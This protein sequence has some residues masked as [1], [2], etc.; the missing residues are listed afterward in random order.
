MTSLP[1][2][3]RF[4]AVTAFLALA[5]V[6][7][8]P[9]ACA[10][11]PLRLF[12]AH[13]HYNQEAMS[14]YPLDK[15]LE[16]FRRNGVAGIL[17]TSRP[18]LGTNQLVEAKPPGLWV[19]P[20]LRPYRVRSDVQTW[21][22]DPA[23]FELIQTEY[24]RGYYRGIGEFHI[25]GQGAAAELVRKTV[26]FAGARDLFLHAHCDEQA[27]IILFSHN[28]RAR[29]IWAHTGF[30]TPV[31]RV[32]ELLDQHPGLIAEMSYRSGITDGAGQLTAEWRELFARYSDRVVIGS[33][34]WINERWFGYDTLMKDYR[35]W[36]AQLPADQAQ[37]IAWG[38]AERLFGP[39]GE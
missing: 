26:E 12:D 33:D 30:T 10:Q 1:R 4:A 11:A 38:N 34:T 6:V 31:P 21:S 19:V 15:A 24:Q 2:I 37:R 22:T 36:L 28:P 29:I 27:L 14:L 3:G 18:N 39:R 25:Y 13:L 35:G 17:A 20:F 23:I 7:S 16:I 8:A 9:G 32:K 5:L